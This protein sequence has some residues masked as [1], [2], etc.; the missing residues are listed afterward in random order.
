MFS[1]GLNEHDSRW[2]LSPSE[3]PALFL[4]LVPDFF[5]SNPF[6]VGNHCSQELIAESRESAAYA[7]VTLSSDADAAS[8]LESMAQQEDDYVDVCLK[9][10][11]NAPRPS[12][13]PP[14]RGEK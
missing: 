6:C 3:A 4:R 11:Q 1:I 2:R 8:F 10:N 12:E 9:K 7:T 13:H 5:L 14:V